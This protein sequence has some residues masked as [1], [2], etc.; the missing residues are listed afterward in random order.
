VRLRVARRACRHRSRIVGRELFL[1]HR[2][3]QPYDAPAFSHPVRELVACE[4]PVHALQEFVLS[5]FALEA[6]MGV[7]EEAV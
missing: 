6:E 1:E 7:T 2:W 4:D 5:L 3:T